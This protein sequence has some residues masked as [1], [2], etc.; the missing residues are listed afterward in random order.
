MDGQGFDRAHGQQRIQGEGE[1]G[2][3]PDL[4][5]GGI[6]Q[7]RQP[8]AAEGLLRGQGEPAGS[9]PVRI[10]FLPARCGFDAANF[11]LGPCPVAR[12]VQRG[13]PLLGKFRGLLENGFCR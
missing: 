5:A 13:Q 2:G 1:I 3:V 6:Q 10:G 12:P 9:G 11:K 7:D 4:G 8:L